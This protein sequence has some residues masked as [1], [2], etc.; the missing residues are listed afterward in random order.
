[1]DAG[2]FVLLAGILLIGA[3]LLAGGALSV[4]RSRPKGGVNGA[5]PPPS[6]DPALPSA[7]PVETAPPKREPPAWRSELQR[8][9]PPDVIVL[10]L[11]RASGGWLVEVEGQRYRRLSEIH[12]DRAATKIMSAIAGLKVFAGIEP[13][14]AAQPAPGPPP[15]QPAPAT[16]ADAPPVPSGLA[17]QRARHATFPAPEGSIIA[18]IETILQRELE[19]TPDLADR[20]IHMGTTPEGGL[21]IEIDHNFY[22]TPDEIPD[23]RIRGLVMLAVRAWEKSS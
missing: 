10:S 3:L 2:G 19:R 21:L 13:A 5:N 17:V 7:S 12:D 23:Q 22:K 4:L 1:M 14:A 15:A 8:R 6:S 18:Q 9:L 11:D 20:N 16:P